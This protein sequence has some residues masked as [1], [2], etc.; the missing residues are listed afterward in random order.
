MS[1]STKPTTLDWA[2]SFVGEDP[3][4]VRRTLT[5]DGDHPA[6]DHR[7]GEIV[8]VRGGAGW[9]RTAEGTRELSA[10]EAFAVR[11][12]KWHAYEECRGLRLTNVNFPLS[13]VRGAVRPLIDGRAMRLLL[14]EG[15][16]DPIFPV[17]VEDVL[18]LPPG[19]ARAETGLLVFLLGAL[20]EALPTS[21]PGLDPS[22][23]R[24]AELLERR[25]GEPWSVA[26]LGAEVGWHPEVL[27]R[28]FTAEL[29]VSP[30]ARLRSLR[31]ERAAFLLRESG[32]P[33][34]A[35]AGAVGY[36]DANLF[37]RRFRSAYGVT[38]SG[39]RAA[40]DTKA[41][42]EDRTRSP[43]NRGRSDCRPAVLSAS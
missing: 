32:T 11:P 39:W 17:G 16:G 31:L 38:P 43:G 14:R 25:M 7:F 27:A 8:F 6:H 24:A 26:R 20:A 35:I 2:T 37:A 41:T 18:D 13:T 12:G 21:A 5:L 4:V 36:A 30:M 10:G 22:V 28:R 42:G 3:G 19:G 15:V 29:G 23:E 9:H 34:G 33:V 1:A 40:T